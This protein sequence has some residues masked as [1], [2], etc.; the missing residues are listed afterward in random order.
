MKRISLL[1]T[2]EFHIDLAFCRIFAAMEL[3]LNV[4][5]MLLSG[6]TDLIHSKL[7]EARSR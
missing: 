5:I 7:L 4:Q 2:F 1:C 6:H 3:I